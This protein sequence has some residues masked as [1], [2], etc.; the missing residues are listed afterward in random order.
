M[1]EPAVTRPPR[2]AGLAGAL[3]CALL[4]LTGTASAEDRLYYIEL[5]VFAHEPGALGASED[6]LAE[7]RG[8]ALSEVRV[9]DFPLQPVWLE[10]EGPFVLG[11]HEDDA[12]TL[13]TIEL[14]ALRRVLAA[15]ELRL[16]D[17]WRRL[18]RDGAYRPLAHA[19]WL[20]QGLTE[21]GQGVTI[22]LEGQLGPALAGS[23][24]VTRSRFVHLQL[25][26]EYLSDG[27]V[28][29]PVAS[30]Q[31]EDGLPVVRTLVPRYRLVQQRRMRNGEVHYFDHP[32]FGVIATI[33]RLERPEADQPSDGFLTR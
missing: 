33:H 22:D 26:L 28:P 16:S 23:A 25:D 24:R 6:F 17:A 8:P 30:A 29:L 4:L 20:Q 10:G 11:L 14:P 2:P 12:D 13:G 27:A 15:D 9:R 31:G 1:D 18:Q 3:L 21:G 19:A 7:P 5:L 32:A